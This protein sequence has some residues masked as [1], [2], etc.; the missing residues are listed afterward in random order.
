[1]H[2]ESVVVEVSGE[3]RLAVS[4]AAKQLTVRRAL[5]VQ[6]EGGRVLGALL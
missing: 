5:L 6:N 2:E 4:I 3:L 1:L